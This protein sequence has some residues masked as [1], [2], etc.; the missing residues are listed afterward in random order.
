MHTLYGN[1]AVP[2]VI[3][4]IMKRTVTMCSVKW[5]G[6]PWRAFSR[7]L[8]HK[9]S[10]VLAANR[11]TSCL[12]IWV[13]FVLY[14][15]SATNIFCTA[16]FLFRLQSRGPSSQSHSYC[17]PQSKHFYTTFPKCPRPSMAMQRKSSSWTALFLQ[18]NKE[19]LLRQYPKDA[20]R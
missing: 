16:T 10:G 12:C 19:E 18:R 4:V 6:T 13:G 8:S 11:S 5:L 1:E 3:T 15:C 2:L 14:I 7:L 20:E 9:S 17:P